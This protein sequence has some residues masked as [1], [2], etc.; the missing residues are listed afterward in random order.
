ML[1][2]V[3]NRKLVEL[4]APIMSRDELRERCS[5]IVVAARG[6]KAVGA[7]RELGVKPQV[8]APE[9]HTWQTLLEALAAQHAAAPASG[10]RC[11]STACRTSG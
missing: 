8:V 1:T 7:L 11:S 10:W 6:P 4:V 2:G 9:P 3:G 5:A